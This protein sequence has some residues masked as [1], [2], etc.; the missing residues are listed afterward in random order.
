LLLL[1]AFVKIVKLSP[2]SQLGDKRLF[3]CLIIIVPLLVDPVFFTK[4]L[5]TQRIVSQGHRQS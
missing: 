1:V 3:Y 2:L 4:I 5:T